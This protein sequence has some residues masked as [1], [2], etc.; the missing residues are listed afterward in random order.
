MSFRKSLIMGS[1]PLPAS[2]QLALFPSPGLRR[3]E[4]QCWAGWRP[5]A[6][7]GR[8]R[9]SRVLDGLLVIF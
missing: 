3:P 7:P 4:S 2:E 5:G 9:A 8:H 1:K 6:A